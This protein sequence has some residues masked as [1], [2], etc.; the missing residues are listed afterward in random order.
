MVRARRALPEHLV[1][2]VDLETR[3]FEVLDHA[4]GEHLA[5]IVR[6]MLRHEPPQQGSAA[7]DREADRE[8]ELVAEGAVIHQGALFWFCSS[9]RTPDAAGAVKVGTIPC[10]GRGTARHL[11]FWRRQAVCGWQVRRPRS[12]PRPEPSGQ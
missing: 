1:L 2:F 11:A 7:A 3:V 4:G 5:G 8:G 6:R 10:G 9:E 12:C